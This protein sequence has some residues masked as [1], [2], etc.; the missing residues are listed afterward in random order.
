MTGEQGGA[1]YLSIG[2][3]DSFCV[4]THKHMKRAEDVRCPALFHSSCYSL[5]TGS[6]IEPGAR[7]EANEPS[8]LLPDPTA[9]VT[10]TWVWPLLA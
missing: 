6:L 4:C 8:I 7:L 10:G 5:Q 2:L 9:E 1:S 3:C